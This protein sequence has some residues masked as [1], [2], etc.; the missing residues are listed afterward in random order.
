MLEEP[1]I[2][3][4]DKF[5]DSS[6]VI[7]GRIR[8]RPIKQWE[9]G[10]EYLRRIKLAFDREG[11]EIPFPHRSIYFGEKSRPFDLALLE[12]MAAGRGETGEPGREAG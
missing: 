2:F 11:I 7:K 1:E 3:G 4:V 9:V 10:R 12:K 8:T 5:A 6:V